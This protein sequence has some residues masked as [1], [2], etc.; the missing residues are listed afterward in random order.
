MGNWMFQAQLDRLQSEI[1]QAAK[2]TGIASATRL[3]TITPKK[4]TV[5]AACF[6]IRGC[7]YKTFWVSDQVHAQAQESSDFDFVKSDLSGVWACF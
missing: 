1:S 7:A 2:K 3:A 5:S 6:F 4:E